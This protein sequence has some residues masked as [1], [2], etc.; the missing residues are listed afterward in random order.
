MIE[1][2]TQRLGRRDYL[3]AAGALR[4]TANGWNAAVKRELSTDRVPAD[5]AQRRLKEREG[6]ED[7]S[8]YERLF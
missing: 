7:G 3:S 6:F 1:M 4:V 8:G 2:I 5:G